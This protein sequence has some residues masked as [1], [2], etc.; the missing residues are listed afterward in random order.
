M[1]LRPGGDHATTLVMA[2]LAA[3][4]LVFALVDWARSGRP[5]VALLF[6][7]GG[8]MAVMEPMVDTVGACWFPVNSTIAYYGWGRPMPVWLCLTYFVYF[9]LGGGVMWMAMRRGIGRAEIWG[10]FVAAMLADV[11]LETV[12]LRANLYAY[13]GWQPLRLGAFPLWWAPVNALV[14]LVAAAATLMVERVLAGWGLVLLLPALLCA[15][16]AANAAVGWPSWFVINSNVGPLLTDLAGLAT[17][18]LAFALVHLL[19]IA[20]GR[21][22]QAGVLG[23]PA[24][25]GA[26]GA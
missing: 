17:F 15:S 19:A 24:R 22:A 18:V 5:V 21:P 11:V 3:A 16:A 4:V 9:G 26:L 10:L 8:G 7:A 14:P 2:A 25:A 20:V 1:Y 13:Y 12:L 6:L 23:R